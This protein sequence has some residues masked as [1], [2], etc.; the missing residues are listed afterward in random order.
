MITKDQIK[1]ILPGVSHL[2]E[3]YPFVVAGMDRFLINTPA[4]MGAYIAQIGEESAN[5]K[6]LREY[7]SGAEYEGRKDLGNTEPGDGVRFKGRGAIMITGRGNYRTTSMELYKDDRLIEHPELLEQPEAAFLSSGLYWR[8]HQINLICDKEEDWH[9][10][11]P[12]NYGKFQWIT[13]LINGGLNGYADRLA[14]Y[15]RARKVLNF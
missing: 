8:D 13:I 7:A 9:H 4:R 12:H 5:F 15:E 3:Y 14:N 11:G 6:A 1:A 10:P 2:D